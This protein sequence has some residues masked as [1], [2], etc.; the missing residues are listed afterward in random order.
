MCSPQAEHREHFLPSSGRFLPFSVGGDFNII[1]NPS[2]KNNSKYINKCVAPLVKCN[3]IE[4]L[5]L[6]ELEFIGRKYTWTS[7]TAI[8]S[9]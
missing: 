3:I 1:T 6:R 7:Y 8:V 4:T 2:E 9:W 5:N